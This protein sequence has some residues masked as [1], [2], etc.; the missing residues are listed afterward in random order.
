[1]QP[2]RTAPAV[3]TVARTGAHRPEDQLVLVVD[4]N[5]DIREMEAQALETDGYRVSTAPNGRVALELAHARRPN[6]ILLDLMMPVMTGWEFL[7][8]LREVP[9]LA[10]VPVVVVTALDDAYPEGAVAFVRKPFFIET[11]LATVAWASDG[12]GLPLDELSE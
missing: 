5:D 9:A 3:D 2:T 11:L 12:E 10:S 7:G 1:M 6:L 8:A 4:D